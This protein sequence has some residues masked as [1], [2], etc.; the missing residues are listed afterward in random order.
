MPCSY[1]KSPNDKGITVKYKSARNEWDL[2]VN[3][4]AGLSQGYRRNQRRFRIRARNVWRSSRLPGHATSCKTICRGFTD[5]EDLS[6][7]IIAEAFL[8][9]LI[10]GQVLLRRSSIGEV[11]TE[12][13]EVS[14]C[15]EAHPCSDDAPCRLSQRK[16]LLVLPIFPEI[17]VGLGRFAETAWRKLNTMAP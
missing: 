8:Y 5:S 3:F 11:I 6:G 13:K 12:S 4:T 17:K 7:R 14:I 10:S 9:G 1:I 15:P 16:H 2:T